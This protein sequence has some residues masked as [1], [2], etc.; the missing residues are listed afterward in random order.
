VKQITVYEEYDAV[1]R[2]RIR[3][4]MR[5][6]YYGVFKAKHPR[7]GRSRYKDHIADLLA[8]YDGDFYLD[9]GSDYD[10]LEEDVRAKTLD[11]FLGKPDD[12]GARMTP[13]EKTLRFC[14][15]YL[16]VKY[17]KIE[18]S[19]RANAFAQDY[20]NFMEAKYLS[21][22]RTDPKILSKVKTYSKSLCGVYASQ[23]LE[24]WPTSTTGFSEQEYK[25]AEKRFGG[26]YRLLILSMLEDE[27]ILLCHYLSCHEADLKHLENGNIGKLDLGRASGAAVPSVVDLESEFFAIR[28]DLLMSNRKENDLPFYFPITIE[29]DDKKEDQINGFTASAFDYAP[30]TRFIRSKKFKKAG[31]KLL[32]LYGVDI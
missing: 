19:L 29:H 16:L 7:A 26:P 25:R 15:A 20:I 27:T 18:N 13:S 10:P 9:C 5:D 11:N 31:N 22:K 2:E 17:P 8:S 4:K 12:I 14:H 3:D 24:N 6:D 1:L 23:A 32:D 21:W 28:F 30:K